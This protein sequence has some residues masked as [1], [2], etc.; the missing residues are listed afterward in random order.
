MKKPILLLLS[1]T[2]LLL[3]SCATTESLKQE[4]SGSIKILN[5]SID[6][7]Y[8]IAM[9]VAT[10]SHLLIITED[11]NKKE[12]KLRSGS[13][14]T[15]GFLC[16]GNLLGVFLGEEGPST[17]RVKIVERF[18]L[19]TQILGCHDKAPAYLAQ[20]E[21]RIKVAGFRGKR[22]KSEGE[23]FS[24]GTGWPTTLGCVVT[25][26]HV[27]QGREKITLILADGNKIPATVLT[28][29]KTNDIVL[30]RVKNPYELPPAL[31]FAATNPRIGAKV[32]TLGY[33]HPDVLGT[34]P[35]FTDGVISSLTGLQDDPR[36][37]QITVPLQAGNS[38]G[39]LLNLNGEVV[40]IVTYK[41]DA[42][43]MYKWTGDLPQ[44]VNYAVKIHYL[45]ALLDSVTDQNAPIN[46]MTRQPANLEQLVER[47][48]GSIIFVLAE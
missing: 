46:E 15:G 36:T 4:S 7:V 24:T 37:Y 44:N 2:F 10:E 48:Q 6:N 14:M 1:L 40:G 42:L 30:L 16:S 28:R 11:P 20:L 47:V 9:D 27:V 41:L 33:P 43:T 5:A 13:Y 23:S 35:K 45:K 19:A 25:N 39:P 34:R 29:D 38:G 17:T 8:Q 21:A 18:V 32:F 22:E 12:I 26:N 31:P 3:I